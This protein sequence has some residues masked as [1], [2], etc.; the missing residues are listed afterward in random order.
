MSPGMFHRMR[1]PRLLTAAFLSHPARGTARVTGWGEQTMS[2][3]TPGI[4]MRAFFDVLILGRRY[5]QTT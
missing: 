3:C 4:W 1:S 5:E 2:W